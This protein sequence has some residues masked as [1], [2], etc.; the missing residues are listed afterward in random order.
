MNQLQRYSKE[1]KFTSAGNT[2]MLQKEFR[3][4]KVTTRIYY[5]HNGCTRMVFRVSSLQFTSAG[6]LN[7]VPSLGG[8]IQKDGEWRR[9]VWCYH[10]PCKSLMSPKTRW[11]SGRKHLIIKIIF[12]WGKREH[13]SLSQS[14]KYQ[15]TTSLDTLGLKHY[16]TPRTLE[17]F[18]TLLLCRASRALLWS[19]Q[20]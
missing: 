1:P 2:K 9:V 8:M 19:S 14:Q 11:L 5:Q 4:T 12:L 18:F 15:N 16:N 10:L 6:E 3:M 7:L 17:T 20:C 13:D